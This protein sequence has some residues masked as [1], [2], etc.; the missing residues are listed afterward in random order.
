ML[1]KGKGS[2]DVGL[3]RSVNQ[4][5]YLI[6]ESKSLFIVADGMGGHAGGEIASKICIKQIDSFFQKAFAS[7]QN[8][9]ESI[10]KACGQIF[11]TSLLNRDLRGMGTTATVLCIKEDKAFVGQVGD[12][13]LYLFRKG[14]LYQITR[15]HSLVSEQVYAGKIS[16]EEAGSHQLRNVI[17]RSVGYLEK[18]LVDTYEFC[19]E[20]EDLLLLCSDGLH[21]KVAD[22]HIAHHLQEKDLSASGP[23]I[24]LA[25]AKG[26]EDNI[27][28]IIVKISLNK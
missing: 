1:A 5:A 28:V 18:E 19:L 16:E 9:E 12:S 24:E 7:R 27:T 26:G 4:D 11:E 13:R 23:L 2:T 21:G 3:V 10:Q 25:K 8:I 22:N 6:D 15:D 17:T 20:P 14:F